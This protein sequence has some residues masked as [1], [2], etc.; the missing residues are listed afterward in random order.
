[1]M[2][3]LRMKILCVMTSSLIDSD[4]SERGISSSDESSDFTSDLDKWA[5][6]NKATGTSLCIE[7]RWK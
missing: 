7:K 6:K 3:A 1:M 4:G 5:V 2:Q